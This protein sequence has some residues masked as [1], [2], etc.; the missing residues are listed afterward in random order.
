MFLIES[1]WYKYELYGKIS[2][3]SCCASLIII[4]KRNYSTISIKGPHR[5]MN[6]QEISCA[7][8]VIDV[9]S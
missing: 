1:A 7:E 9:I 5:V 4:A 8:V 3:P 6:S 2:S